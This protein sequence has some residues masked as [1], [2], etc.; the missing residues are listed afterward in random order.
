MKS[1]TS[2]FS[3]SSPIAALVR[4]RCSPAGAVRLR[5]R[6]A[7]PS[8]S[9]RPRPASPLPARPG[10]RP[11]PA[12]G[13]SPQ[14]CSLQPRPGAPPPLPAR[15]PGRGAGNRPHEAQPRPCRG[16]RRQQLGLGGPP[17]HP[18]RRPYCHASELAGRPRDDKGLP[19]GMEPCG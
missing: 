11:L 3:V 8:R 19:G 18:A 14:P 16:R 2:A 7:S 1:C 4:S 13:S 15:L 6:A 10:Q 5:V 9:A 17:G 12:A